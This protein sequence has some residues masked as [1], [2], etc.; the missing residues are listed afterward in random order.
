MVTQ[1]ISNRE[2]CP[3]TECDQAELNRQSGRIWGLTTYCDIR[4]ISP[5]HSPS[6]T[7]SDNSATSST[8]LTASSTIFSHFHSRHWPMVNYPLQPLA[9]LNVNL[10][11]PSSSTHWSFTSC[12][13][14]CGQNCSCYLVGPSARNLSNTLK[15]GCPNGCICVPRERA[16]CHDY[17]YQ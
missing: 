16:A 6:L 4:P 7:P 1:L 8:H 2:L 12:S 13:L 11:L 14:L 15:H 5:S 9:T 17:N 3:A 10:N